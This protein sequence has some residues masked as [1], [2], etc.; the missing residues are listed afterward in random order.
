MG[1]GARQ[2]RGFWLGQWGELLMPFTESETPWR[3]RRR[4]KN[5]WRRKE[6]RLRKAEFYEPVSC[7][8]GALQ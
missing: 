4:R 6:L 1:H 3:R 2:R 5:S 8:N 7:P